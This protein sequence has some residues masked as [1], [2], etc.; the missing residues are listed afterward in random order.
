[1]RL[2]L[3]AGTGIDRLTGLHELPVTK[4]QRFAGSGERFGAGDE[5]TS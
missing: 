1:M 2:K 3:G 5:R 4:Q